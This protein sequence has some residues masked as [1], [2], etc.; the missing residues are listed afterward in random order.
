MSIE[1]M[2]A[3]AIAPS[4][5]QSRPDSVSSRVETNEVSSAMSTKNSSESSNVSSVN[6]PTT[7]EHK[8]LS[9]EKLEEAIDKL[10]DMMRDGQ[11]S[12]S[13]SVDDSAEKVVVR[14]VDVQTSEVIRQIPT[15]ETLKFA[16]Y[17]E[18]MVGLL[19]NDKA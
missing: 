9:I 3:A 15:E 19:F 8:V 12:L 5:S 10:N 6:A 14:V 17:L 11:R 13:F 18:G 7:E 16:E 1:S 4:A 2:N